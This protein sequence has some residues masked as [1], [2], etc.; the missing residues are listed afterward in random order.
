MVGV[1]LAK[2][3]KS[4]VFKLVLMQEIELIQ[5]EILYMDSISCYFALLALKLEYLVMVA[6]FDLTFVLLKMSKRQLQ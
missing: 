5:K 2:F 1:A 3:L 6:T 4:Q